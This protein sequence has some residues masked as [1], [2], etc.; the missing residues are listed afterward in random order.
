[1]L[2]SDTH[3]KA[4]RP[5]IG[6]G[7]LMGRRDHL[8]WF[9]SVTWGDIGWQLS[10]A[11][12][13]NELHEALA[14]VREH[15]GKDIVAIF[16]RDAADV[17]ATGVELRT[18]RKELNKAVDRIPIAYQEQVS[19][20]NLLREAEMAIQ[21]NRVEGASTELQ[22]DPRL[23]EKQRNVLIG[24]LKKRQ[25]KFQL[26]QSAYLEYR[27]SEQRLRKELD[28][29]DAAFAQG[30]LLDYI[31]KGQYARNPL[32]LANAMAG[33]PNITW[34]QSYARC[35]KIR[36]SGWPNLWFSVFETIEDIWNMRTSFPEVGVV[37]LFRR[38][39]EKLPRK[40]LVYWETEKKKILMPNQVRSRLGDNFRL[41]RMAIEEAIQLNLHPGRTPFA[42]TSLFEKNIEK[43]RSPAESLQIADEAIK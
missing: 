31:A 29:N 23:P 42:I 26:A 36:C 10:R 15:S 35:S 38:E 27:N 19:C 28:D 2:E 24:E 32:S 33:L 9:L 17:P 7:V 8:V 22:L 6:D 18:L 30:E 13:A 20:A 4:G 39:V 5:T 25:T 43:T 40:N 21:M 14:P 41:L 12:S 37:E 3:K 11:S 1:M 16:A 34:P